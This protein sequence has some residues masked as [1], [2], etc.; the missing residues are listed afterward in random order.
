MHGTSAFTDTHDG[1]VQFHEIVLHLVVCIRDERILSFQGSSGLVF[2]KVSYQVLAIIFCW[3]SG[4]VSF[5]ASERASC[6]A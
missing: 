2:A 6:C 1:V 4:K 5:E 3:A